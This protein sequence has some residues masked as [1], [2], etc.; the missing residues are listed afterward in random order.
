MH[1]EGRKTKGLSFSIN[2]C[3]CMCICKHAHT[4]STDLQQKML[5][6]SG[7]LWLST[8]LSV[9]TTVFPFGV[10]QHTLLASAISSHVPPKV[11]PL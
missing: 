11:S 7:C 1:S 2:V 6:G 5:N 3:E 10:F 4:H 8:N 9:L